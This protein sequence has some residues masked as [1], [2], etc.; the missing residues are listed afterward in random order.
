M[1]FITGYLSQ[2][3]LSE[4]DEYMRKMLQPYLAFDFVHN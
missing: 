4:I 3:M 2:D 1:V